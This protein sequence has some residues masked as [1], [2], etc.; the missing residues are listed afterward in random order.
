[1]SAHKATGRTK[2]KPRKKTPRKQTLAAA[3][4]K[5]SRKSASGVDPV[6]IAGAMQLPTYSVAHCPDRES[7]RA[8]MAATLDHVEMRIKGTRKWLGPKLK[9]IVLPEYL[10]TSFP[11]GEPI[12][13]WADKAALEMNGPEYEQFGRIAQD[14]ALFLAGNAYETDPN[15]PGFYF[16]TSF[17]VGPSGD[18]ILRY[19][20]LNSMYSPSPHDV[21]D[22]YLDLYG[23]EAVFPV[24]DTEIGKLAPIASE[25]ILFP[26]VARCFAMRGAEVFTH[27]SSEFSSPAQTRKDAAKLCRAIENI[28]YVVSANTGGICDTDLPPDSSNGGSRV[29]DFKGKVMRV[30]GHGDNSGANAEIDLGALRRERRKTGLSN[31][32]VRQ[33]FQ[34]YADSYAKHDFQPANSLITK[35]G[36]LKVPD[37]KHFAQAQEAVISRLDKKG[38][39]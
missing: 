18:V 7:A 16:Q 2:K 36:R 25:E 23:L 37:R 32:L 15:F 9:L 5:R 10:L 34:A 6:Y 38:I 30:A 29:I 19:R 12:A 39:I 3:Q 11:E 33:R 26:E 28:A 8:R 31:T 13:Q 1:M 35:S 4:P 17:I 24:A 27:S 20:R 22:K 21:W 14:N